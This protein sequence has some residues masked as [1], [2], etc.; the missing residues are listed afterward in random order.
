MSKKPL[1]IQLE[2]GAYPKDFDWQAMTASDRGCYHS[3]IIFLACNEG[4]LP[5]N[6]QRLAI[7]CNVDVKTFETFWKCYSH[8]FIEKE[9][10][11]EHKRINEELSKARKY[12]KQKSLA[13]K[14]G[15][16]KRYNA[17]TT[18]L[19]QESNTDITK[20]SKEKK[21]EVK[22][23][24]ENNNKED[25]YLSQFNEARTLY[26]GTKRGNP[27]EFANFKKKHG[28]WKTIIPLLLPAI[29]KQKQWRSEANGEFRPPWKIFA[30]WINNS[31]WEDSVDIAEATAD[32]KACITCQAPYVLGGHKFTENPQTHQKEYRCAKCRGAK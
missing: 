1:Y 6:T 24:K 2:P 15:M 25:I 4:S 22:K 14:K 21:R 18:P 8:K 17:V 19:K 3:L 7:L 5:N 20:G 16:K 32:N 11:I 31:C 28:D 26:P 12:I 9:G 13:G 29:Q 10:V 23:I 27:T 30:T